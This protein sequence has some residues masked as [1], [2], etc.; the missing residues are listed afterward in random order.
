MKLITQYR[1]NIKLIFRI[2]R[3]GGGYAD[4]KISMK[5]FSSPYGVIKILF[6]D[7]TISIFIKIPRKCHITLAKQL[8]GFVT[9]VNQKEKFE[10]GMTSYKYCFL[11]GW[12]QI[13]EIK[14]LE[15]KRVFDYFFQ[16]FFFHIINFFS[17]N[18]VFPEFFFPDMTSYKYCFLIG[19]SQVSLYQIC[20]TGY[21]GVPSPP[22]KKGPQK[23]NPEKDIKTF[24]K[25]KI[26]G[27]KKVLQFFFAG[28]FFQIFFFSRFFFP[29]FIFPRFSCF[30]NLFFLFPEFSF[31]QIFFSSGYFFQFFFQFFSLNTCKHAFLPPPPPPGQDTPS[32]TAT[33]LV[34]SFFFFFWQHVFFTYF[35][36]SDFHQTWS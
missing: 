8:W 3:G 18:F 29:E 9:Q 28:F 27:K 10:I 6:S 14:I 12:N 17:R 33:C 25:K 21:Y 24:W 32:V 20:Y 36:T 4:P 7:W 15:K 35:P 16:G 19:W 22:Q 34:L 31:F 1:S 5:V 11:I 23:K 2:R 30:Q 13:L 26:F